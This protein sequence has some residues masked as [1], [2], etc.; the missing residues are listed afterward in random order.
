MGR[1]LR[2]DGATIT[3]YLMAFYP[4][5]HGHLTQYAYAFCCI[6]ADRNINRPTAKTACRVQSAS[7]HP[8]FIIQQAAA[9]TPT[10]GRGRTQPPRPLRILVEKKILLNV[11]K[12]S[13]R[14]Q[15]IQVILCR[16]TQEMCT[17]QVSSLSGK[18]VKSGINTD[19]LHSRRRT[20]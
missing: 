5:D 2:D 7:A 16:P 1:P 9:I 10:N 19:E 8:D 14:R 17:S 20:Y 11:R 3:G 4:S 6:D 12:L 13:N 15:R 18:F